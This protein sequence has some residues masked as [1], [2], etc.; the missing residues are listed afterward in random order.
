[1][2]S[3]FTD[4]NPATAWFGAIST[5]SLLQLARDAG[6]A[7][8]TCAAILIIGLLLSHL[9]RQA[10]QK[11]FAL[12]NKNK[13]QSGKT[14]TLSSVLRNCVKY[15]IWFLIVCQILTV[16]GV[17][18][19]P[20]VALAS[21]ASVALGFGSQAIVKDF[22]TGLFI[23]VENQFNVGDVVTIG[24]LSGAVESVGIRTT[25]IRSVNGDVH[26]LPNGSISVVTNMSK[27]HKKAIVNLDFSNQHAVDPILR[28][29]TEEMLAA[30]NIP[31]LIAFPEVLGLIDLT[32]TTFKVQIS[33]ACEPDCCWPVEREIR[34]LI[35]IR[36]EKDLA[37]S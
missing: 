32:P 33:A 13:T 19:A 30:R 5:S 15:V 31:G 1:M 4:S 11:F 29:L 2:A 27:E 18:A 17:Q 16:F 35:K 37:Y 14:E 28:M 25:K 8:F 12:S 24:G 22:I 36:M 34:R 9:L 3:Y 21:V 10:I 23:L 7:M 6:L 26:I 20:L